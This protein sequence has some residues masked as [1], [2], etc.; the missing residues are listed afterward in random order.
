M[1]L[2]IAAEVAFEIGAPEHLLRV[3][4]APIAVERFLRHPR[5]AFDHDYKFYHCRPFQLLVW[6]ALRAPRGGSVG[7]ISRSLSTGY[8]PGKHL[9]RDS[10]EQTASRLCRGGVL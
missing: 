7:C 6:I 2:H 4:A 1:R 10:R 8:P 5:L 3:R 9:C